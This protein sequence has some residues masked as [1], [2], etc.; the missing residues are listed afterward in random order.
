MI[1]CRLKIISSNIINDIDTP[2]IKYISK[3]DMPNI[4]ISETEENKE[5]EIYQNNE[6]NPINTLTNQI[7]QTNSN[8][9]SEHNES[10]NEQKYNNNNINEIDHIDEFINKKI[11]DFIQLENN[12]SKIKENKNIDNNELYTISNQ[13]IYDEN[14]Y[15]PKVNNNNFNTISNSNK[16]ESRNDSTNISDSKKK[17]SKLKYIFRKR[18]NKKYVNRSFS[19]NKYSKENQNN[20]K[21]NLIKNIFKTHPVNYN[22]TNMKILHRNKSSNKVGNILNININKSFCINNNIKINNKN[23]LQNKLKSKISN[24]SKENKERNSQNK[25]EEK[26]VMKKVKNLN[27]KFNKRTNKNKYQTS[28]SWNV[29]ENKDKNY[30]QF[31]D[32]KTL[33]DELEKKECELI[34]EK[35]NMI[36]TYEQKLKPIRELNSKLINEN[37]DELDKDDELKGELVIL[38]NQYEIL[39]AKVNKNNENN[40]NKKVNSDINTQLSKEVQ[41]IEQEMQELNDKLI[42]GEI[43][44]VTKPP[45]TIDISKKKEKQ[46]ILMLKGLFYSVHIRDTDEIV[47]LIWKC[48]HQIQTI[49]FLINEFVKIF[50]L[51]NTDKNILINFFYSFCEKYNYM[52][53]NMFKKEF[54]NKIGFIPIYNK[55]IYISR[56]LNFH[57]TKIVELFK[58]IREIDIFNIGIIS[59]NKLNKLLND[60]YLFKISG[61]NNEEIY[62]FVMIIMKKNRLIKFAKNNSLL[63]II[64]RKEQIKYSLFDLFYESLFDLIKEHNSKIISNSFQL[65]KN[66]MTKNDINDAES[67]FKPLLND[68]FI[69]KINNNEYFDFVILNKYLR[70]LGIIKVNEII[71]INCFEEE[72]VDKDNF[73]KNIYNSGINEENETNINKLK[74]NVNDFINEIFKNYH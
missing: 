13:H 44:I 25:K 11:E 17:H 27:L 9:V 19:N 7:E 1:K 14:H 37:D 65:I 39:F 73:F 41:N 46:I 49:Y 2:Q 61:K 68:K 69:L 48:T 70:K 26:D 10:N 18:E 50:S 31:I 53:I 6:N 63:E 60:L 35:E 23:I 33:I 57:R 74:D 40:E 16:F 64:E 58:L 71:S 45:Y 12:D 8:N 5:I 47:N 28:T 15:S 54:K 34:K 72:L 51:K 29:V 20:K 3:N 62:D 55:N 24:K 67:L 52:D 4:L 22:Y 56:L 38:K 43:L 36:Q 66:Y 30:E 21:Y 59:F 42:K 32:Y